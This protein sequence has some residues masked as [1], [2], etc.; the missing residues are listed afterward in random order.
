MVVSADAPLP[1]SDPM[2]LSL[3]LV[4]IIKRI[5][6]RLS[7]EVLAPALR[8]RLAAWK[9]LKAARFWAWLWQAQP[10]TASRSSPLLLFSRFRLFY[11]FCFICFAYFFCGQKAG[12][13]PVA[14]GMRLCFGY[15]AISGWAFCG[16]RLPKTIEFDWM[17]RLAKGRPR[18]R[19][20][21]TGGNH[22]AGA[23][24][25]QTT[26]QSQ[27]LSTPR[28]RRRGPETLLKDNQRHLFG[29][30]YYR[31]SSFLAKKWP[32]K[33]DGQNEERA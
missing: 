17:H 6:V 3:G 14:V 10:Y 27:Q 31:R 2:I 28:R 4:I 33:D 13:G 9:E 32:E 22:N 24:A 29:P 1:L 15:F 21:S 8:M 7:L 30:K 20:H 23:A 25:A 19:P 12:A 16:A 26:K 11:L 5:D 18:I